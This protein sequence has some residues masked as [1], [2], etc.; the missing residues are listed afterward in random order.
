[1]RWIRPR[2]AIPVLVLGILAAVCGWLIVGISMGAAAFHAER[3]VSA[4]GKLDPGCVAKPPPDWLTNLGGGL[5]VGGVALTVVGLGGLFL[6][7]LFRPA[8]AA[9]GTEVI[10]PRQPGQER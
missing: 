5:C 2:I 9:T 8:K 3:C 4:A 7:L 10:S 1:M 6:C